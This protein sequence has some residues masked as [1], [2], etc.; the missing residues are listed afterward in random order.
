MLQKN[1]QK[2]VITLK[3]TYLPVLRLPV[4]CL[5]PPACGQGQTGQT[6]MFL[7]INA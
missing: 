3:K 4:A 7:K 2:S 5:S 1:C 6:G